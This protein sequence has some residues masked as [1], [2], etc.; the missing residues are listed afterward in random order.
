MKYKFFILI[1]AIENY[2]IPKDGEE[3]KRFVAFCNYYRRFIK[4]FAE[5]TK[6]LNDLNKK[7][8]IFEWTPECQKSFETLKH[9]L[10]NS[11]ILQYPDFVKTFGTNY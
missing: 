4:D 11:P 10:I 2:S 7:G 6:C 1:K 3:V 8:K 5:L 9:K